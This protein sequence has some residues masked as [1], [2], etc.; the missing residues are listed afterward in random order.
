MA[1]TTLYHLILNFEYPEGRLLKVTAVTLLTVCVDSNRYGLELSAYAVVANFVESSLALWV[2]AVAVP[3]NA[4]PFVLP[5]HTMLAV[6]ACMVV[7]LEVLVEPSV[8][9]FVAL[10]VAILT[11][12]V[13]LSVETFKAF[14]PGL[15]V[16]VPPEIEEFPVALMPPVVAMSPVPAVTDPETEGLLFRFTVT[17][18]PDPL[19]FML[20][21]PCIVNALLEGVAVPESVGNEVE[22]RPVAAIVMVESAPVVVTFDPPAILIFAAA[23]NADPLLVL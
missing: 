10:P 1:G 15:S 4:M 12:V 14:E 9:V 21:P 13:A 22:I 18:D 23:G 20:D 8:V 3:L 19:V 6:P 5:V 11:V 2:V 7:E 16:I 17:V